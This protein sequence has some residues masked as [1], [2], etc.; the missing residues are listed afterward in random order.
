M[1]KRYMAGDPHKQND[2][3]TIEVKEKS[4]SPPSQ[5]SMYD[6]ASQYQSLAKRKLAN[7]RSTYGLKQQN[8]IKAINQAKKG[9][10]MRREMG[11]ERD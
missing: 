9:K 5:T 3:Y 11:Y 7:I 6:G 4:S 1:A 8:P 10:P 2:D